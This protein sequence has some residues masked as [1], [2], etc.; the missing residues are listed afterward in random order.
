MDYYPTHFQIK[1]TSGC[2]D[3]FVR[4]QSGDMMAAQSTAQEGQRS[5]VARAFLKRRR[6][7]LNENVRE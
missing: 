1:F 5:Q 3:S 4:G 7:I 6:E 2:D